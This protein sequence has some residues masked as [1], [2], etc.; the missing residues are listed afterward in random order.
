MRTERQR[1]ANLAVLLVIVAG[2]TALLQGPALWIGQLIVAAA[3]AFG[4]FHY[5]ADLDPRG[6]PIESLAMPVVATDLSG[7]F[8]VSVTLAPLPQ[9]LLLPADANATDACAS[10]TWE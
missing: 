7:G 6:V 4:A 9:Y 8:N 1:T 5:L 2:V 10:L 3:T